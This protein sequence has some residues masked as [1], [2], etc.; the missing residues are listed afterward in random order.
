MMEPGGRGEIEKEG[1]KRGGRLKR[2]KEGVGKMC[3]CGIYIFGY[4]V[5]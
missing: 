3:V 5:R 4:E 1:K 2:T